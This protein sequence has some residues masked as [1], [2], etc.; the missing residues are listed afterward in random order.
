[1]FFKIYSLFTAYLTSIYKAFTV[2]LASDCNLFTVSLTSVC[3][4]LN[5]C[6]QSICNHTDITPKKACHPRDN[7]MITGKEQAMFSLCLNGLPCGAKAKALPYIHPPIGEAHE[8]NCSLVHFL[9]R[10]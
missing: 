4:L 7:D 3:N 1:M 5:T 9:E 2:Y 6:L 10:C 8:K